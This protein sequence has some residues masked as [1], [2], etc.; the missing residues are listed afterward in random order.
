MNNEEM[1]EHLSGATIYGD[2]FTQNEIQQWFA[3]EEEGYAELGPKN[4]TAYDYQYHALN[5][6]HAFRYLKEPVYSQILSIG[7]AYG[8]ELSPLLSRTEKITILDPSSAFLGHAIGGVPVVYVKPKPDGIMPF[9]AYTFD[10]VT[11]FGCLHH[12]PNVSAVLKETFR[13]LKIGGVALI[14][15]PIISMGD[16]NCPRVGLTKRER[17]IPLV[18]FRVA[19]KAA[20]FSIIR[21][22]FCGFSLTGRLRSF[23]RKSPYNSPIAVKLDQIVSRL[24]AWNYTYHQTSFFRKFTPTVISY[25]VKKLPA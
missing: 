25:V 11:C 2:T 18:P 8:D 16:W 9:Q 10:L 22:T 21:E 17:G 7:G 4:R 12:I 5:Q 13:C 14:R 6:A 3:D 19:L 24:F 15:E 23:L 20:G 1:K